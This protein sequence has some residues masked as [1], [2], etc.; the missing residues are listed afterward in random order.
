MHF[1]FKKLLFVE[2][3]IVKAVM[4]QPIPT[5][6]EISNNPIEKFFSP[7]DTF[8]LL[9]HLPQQNSPIHAKHE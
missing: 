8:L 6:E 3:L 1:V 2:R 7:S 5:S 9:L 4:Q